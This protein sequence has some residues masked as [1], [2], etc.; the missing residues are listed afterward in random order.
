[1][2]GFN[3]NFNARQGHRDYGRHRSYSISVSSPVFYLDAT[4]TA[5]SIFSMEAA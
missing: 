5:C 3:F 2:P 1:M 4:G